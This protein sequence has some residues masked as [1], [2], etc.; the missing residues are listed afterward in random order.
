MAPSGLSNTQASFDDAVAELQSALEN[1]SG[2]E[3][4]L[5]N[6]STS[7]PLSLADVTQV[8]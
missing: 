8:V 6:R 1:I 3:F 2:L 4:R 7:P 5:T